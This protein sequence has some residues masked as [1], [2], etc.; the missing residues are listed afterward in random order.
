MFWSSPKLWPINWIWWQWTKKFVAL[1]H[2]ESTFHNIPA[3]RY[4]TKYFAN[5]VW[6]PK[7]EWKSLKHTLTF[8]MVDFIYAITE[9]TQS[10]K[11]QKNISIDIF[12]FYDYG[13]HFYFIRMEHTDKRMNLCI[14]HIHKKNAQDHYD[15]WITMV[16]KPG[17]DRQNFSYYPVELNWKKKQ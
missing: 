10:L 7:S 14:H 11:V 17:S 4:A 13:E 8:G 16:L 1:E 12:V 5:I 6:R 9:G 2:L 15:T 3:E